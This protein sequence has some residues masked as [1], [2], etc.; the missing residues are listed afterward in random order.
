MN[1][2]ACVRD[3]DVGSV[4]QQVPWIQSDE[5]AAD[6]RAYAGGRID[7]PFVDTIIFGV[8]KPQVAAVVCDG[9]RQERKLLRHTG[10]EISGVDAEQLAGRIIAPADPEIRAVECYAGGK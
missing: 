1:V 5:I 10:L 3:P 6:R 8:G 9:A 7:T 4:E 2:V